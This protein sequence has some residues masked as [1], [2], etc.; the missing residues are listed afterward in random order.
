MQASYARDPIRRR[1]I[2]KTGGIMRIDKRLRRHLGVAVAVAAALSVMSASAAELDRSAARVTQAKAGKSLT[3]ASTASPETVVTNYLRGQGRAAN[4]VNSL[5]VAN[6]SDGANGVKHVQ[7][8]QQVDGLKVQGAYVKGAINQRGE[9]VQVIDR[10]V[11]VSTPAPS[12]INA[13]QAL[14]AALTKV[15]PG[16]TALVLSSAGTEGNTTRFNGGAF[17]HERPTATAVVLPLAEGRLARGWLVET[18]TARTNQLHHTI[19]DGDG[20]VLDVE[21]RTANDTYNIFIE[22]PLKGAQTIVNGPGNGNVQSP[23]GWLGAG[24]QSTALISGNNVA[25]YLDTDGNNQPDKGGTP[26]TSGDFVT[27]VDFATAPTTDSNQTVAVQNLF[28]LNNVIHD[29]L[30]RHG[31]TEVAGN[32]QVDNFGRGGRGSDPVQAEAQDGDGTDNANF[33]TPPD[34]RSP[35]MQM[36]LFTGNGETHEVVVNSPV[37]AKYNA[38]TASFGEQLTKTG[39]TGNAVVAEPADGCTT[40]SSAVAGQIAVID[41]GTC[42]FGLKALNA[43][44]AKARAVIIANNQGGTTVIPMGPGLVGS[45][46]KI[47]AVMISQN[48]GAAL[49]ALASPNVTLREVAVLPL[50][51]DSTLDSDVVFH[52]YGHGLSWRMIGGMSGP[53]AGAIGEGNSDGIA[54]LING[55][56]RIA[57]YATSSP[58]GFRRAPYAGYPLTYK[59]VTGAEVHNDG[60]IYAAVIWRLIELF[61]DDRRAELFRYVVDGMNFTPA[62][63]AYEDM[64]D[65]ILASVANGPKATDC[66]LVWQAFAQFGIGVGA[67]GTVTPAGVQVTESFQVPD[68]CAAQ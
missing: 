19:V 40:I 53:L 2:E 43:Q 21:T 60:E 61:G 27:A 34:G 65:G 59:N 22:D 64:R 3:A 66:N 62:T 41:R 18:W 67:Q 12:R 51:I 17:F 20:R 68:N 24:A 30:Y 35:R 14:Q 54:M 1:P 28:Y 55:D 49:K 6:R 15:H 5:R 9:L 13:L 33:S 31:F 44:K 58:A 46:V 52:E 48:D 25:T 50:Q 37:A 57:E 23:A 11:A 39:V 29:T 10:T 38:A 63:P 4:V 7:L 36:F 47:P 56:D 42:E 8:E 26:V 16:E 45:K 32:F